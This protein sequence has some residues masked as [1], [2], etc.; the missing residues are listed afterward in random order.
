MRSE[1]NKDS[2]SHEPCTISGRRR[3]LESSA[4]MIVYGSIAG[5][6]WDEYSLGY[7]DDLTQDL[8]Y[9]SVPFLS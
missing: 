8:E 6:I 9:Q 2:R 7:E 5:M 4:V 1:W 3:G